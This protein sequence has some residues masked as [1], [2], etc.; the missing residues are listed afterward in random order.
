M[1]LRSLVPR[2]GRGRAKLARTSG[3]LLPVRSPSRRFFAPASGMS[4]VLSFHIEWR[5]STRGPAGSLQTALD[6]E[7]LWLCTG[8]VFPPQGD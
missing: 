7:W 4:A 2:R 1:R 6:T 3:D 5:V 8:P